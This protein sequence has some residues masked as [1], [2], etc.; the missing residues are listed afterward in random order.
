MKVLISVLT[1]ICMTVGA[2]EIIPVTSWPKTVATSG[3]ITYNATEQDCIKAGYRLI[4]A[5][6]ETPAGKQITSEALMQDDKSARMA[7]W[8]VVYEAVPI[9]E[10]IPF[11]EII[12]EVL[13]NVPASKVTFVFTTNGDFRAAIW[14]ETLGKTN[15][16]V[17]KEI[18]K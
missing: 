12:P 1:F 6:P 8:V 9:V 18:A 7:K 2:A 14:T 10:P 5:K 16:P 15:L 17:I 13:T 11:P 4:P 3:G